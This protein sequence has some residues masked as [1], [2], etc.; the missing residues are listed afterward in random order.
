MT[1]GKRDHLELCQVVT[2]STAHLDSKKLEVLQHLT[3]L[4]DAGLHQDRWRQL[5]M[6][7]DADS[8]GEIDR[9]ELLFLRGRLGYDTTK[10]Y[11]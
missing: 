1:P 3:R 7:A 4:K 6:E 9:G 5:F 11:G 10:D 2:P 8:S